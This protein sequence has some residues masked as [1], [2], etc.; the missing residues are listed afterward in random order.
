MAQ[1]EW[2][3]I[4]RGRTTKIKWWVVM[5]SPFLL[6]CCT[7]VSMFRGLRCDLR[8]SEIRDSYG[9]EYIF[10]FICRLERHRHREAY[11]ILWIFINRLL[12]YNAII[13]AR[14]I[15]NQDKPQLFH[16]D[17]RS[18]IPVLG[19]SVTFDKIS[20]WFNK[21]NKQIIHP[22]MYVWYGMCV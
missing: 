7:I 15:L 3:W 18:L 19:F 16:H 4:G 5:L 14:N 13:L 21:R 11:A 8:Q 10:L 1:S 9:V 6:L 22:R 2:E 17:N 12:C 20:Q